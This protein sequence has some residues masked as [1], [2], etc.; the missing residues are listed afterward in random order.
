MIFAELIK[1]GQGEGYYTL[2]Y[3][4]YNGDIIGTYGVHFAPGNRAYGSSRDYHRIATPEEVKAYVTWNTYNK[5]PSIEQERIDKAG[6]EPP[7]ARY[8]DTCMY[9]DN[10][11]C[12]CDGSSLVEIITDNEQR[13]F[14]IAAMMAEVKR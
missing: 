12:V 3:A 5:L 7:Y 10:K 14:E 11:A 13:C 1:E 6:D 9:H 2:R 8:V 4:V